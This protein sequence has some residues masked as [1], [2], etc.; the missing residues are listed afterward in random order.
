MEEQRK[1]WFSR[2]WK[3]ALPTFG[4]LTIIV[5]AIIFAIALYTGVSTLF[6][7]SEPYEAAMSSLN[8]NELVIE[9]LGQPIEA[10]GMFQ[11]N[12]N[13]ENNTASADIK[14]PVKGPKGEG[15]LTVIA[16][17]NNDIWTYQ[18]MQVEIDDTEEFI[19]LLDENNKLL[20]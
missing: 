5:L 1:N 4:C 19:N 7:D 9:K 10:D 8:N 20:E 13:Y 17:K 11:G 12:I 14:V 6:K 16:E 15:T 3:W 2:N 18:L